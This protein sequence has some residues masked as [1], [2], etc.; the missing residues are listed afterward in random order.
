MN[1]LLL[2][3]ALA[4]SLAACGGMSDDDIKGAIEAN[5][6]GD[7]VTMSER[8]NANI[9]GLE[10]GIVRGTAQSMRTAREA[11][12][13]LAAG[14][15]GD[16]AQMAIEEGGR[17]A[18]EFGIEGA[19]E[20]HRSMGL[21]NASDWTV[22][23]LEVLSSRTSGDSYI[24]RVRYDLSATLN[25]QDEVLGQDL[26]HMVRLVELDGKWVIQNDENIVP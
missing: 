15:V 13:G 6:E 21:A 16:V 14:I 9:P 10:R 11:T 2:I 25:G 7:P 8:S 1:K 3:S 24:A 23:N 22:R 5:W 20:L 12:D 19:D 4:W 17:L 18:S 26:S